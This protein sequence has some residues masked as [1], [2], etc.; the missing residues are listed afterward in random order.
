MHVGVKEAVAQRMAQEGLDHRAREALEIEALGFEQR[1]VGERRRVDPFEREH[2]ARGAVPVH[3]RHA[4]V[5]IVAGVLRHLRER[6]RLEPQIHLDRDRAPQ[7]LDHLDQPQPPR[8]RRH[9][10][11]VARDKG[12]RVEIDL[13]ASLDLRPQHLHRDGAEATVG[14]DLGA[15]HLRDRSGGDRRAERREQVGQRL[16]QRG[17]RRRARPR[18]AGTAASCPA[19]PRGRAPVARRPHPAASPGTGRA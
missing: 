6:R 3:R 11:G 15:V 14:D 9:A 12:E 5:G 19:A 10:L 2:V 1:A 18:P 7:R 13:E 8:L 16:A 4:E 17:S